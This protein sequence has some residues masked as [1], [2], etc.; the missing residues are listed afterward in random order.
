VSRGDEEDGGD[1]QIQIKPG[2]VLMFVILLPMFTF[3]F[4]YAN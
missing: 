1:E 3:I 4:E 2:K